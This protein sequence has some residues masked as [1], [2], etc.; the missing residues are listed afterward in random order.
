MKTRFNS[1]QVFS[2]SDEVLPNHLLVVHVRVRGKFC[3]I[4]SFPKIPEPDIV[5]AF[6]EGINV[7]DRNGCD[8]FSVPKLLG[9][10]MSTPAYVDS[11]TITQA[12]GAQSS[13]V[14]VPLPDDTYVAVRQAYEEFEAS[15]PLVT[16]T[17]S[18][19][20]S[21]SSDF[22]APLSPDHPLTQ[23][24]PTRVSFYYRTVHMAETPSP[25][26]SLTLPIRKR[27]RGTSEL[28]L[29]TEIED[30][31]SD[32]D[33]EG[34]GSKDESPGLDDEGHGLKDKGPGSDDED[35]EATPKDQQHAV[36]VRDT[37]MD[38]P[39]GLR[40]GALKRCVLALREGSV[41]STFEF[42][43]TPT[44]TISVD[45]DKFLEV[46]AQLELHKSILYDHMQRLDA[47]P[48]TLFKGYDRDL[49][50]LYTRSGARKNHDLRRQ[51][52]EERRDRLELTD[53]VAKIERRQ[54][55]GG[56]SRLYEILD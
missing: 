23:A 41:P 27:Y 13:R 7:V 21:A 8:I 28:I 44:V 47:L 1:S 15:N 32:L 20:S 45:E 14:P 22:T 18:S 56:S 54:E 52:A 5:L 9:G 4:M 53:H 29:D 37:V 31:S 49:R 6:M 19:H 25:S 24:S 26:S 34:E 16:R 55:S 43:T 50:E 40:Y 51:I 42:Q 48:P 35:D 36:L 17:I 46:R 12:D 33:V 39:L 10:V 38:E 30:E 2:K 3:S 11:E